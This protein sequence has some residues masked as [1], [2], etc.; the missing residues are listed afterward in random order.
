M[1]NQ[2][3]NQKLQTFLA[4]DQA[5]QAANGAPCD[6]SYYHR[7]NALD[8]RFAAHRVTDP[9]TTAS[10]HR[11]ASLIANPAQAICAR[12]DCKC[13]LIHVSYEALAMPHVVATGAAYQ[14][15]SSILPHVSYNDGDI[16]IPFLNSH[17]LG[18]LHAHGRVTILRDQDGEY[19]VWQ[20]GDPTKG[21]AWNVEEDVDLDLAKRLLGI[22]A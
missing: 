2:Y 17:P 18:G 14:L 19:A 12:D 20:D 21:A 22:D 3:L 5:K 13:K 1:R 11:L 15:D 7:F 6:A 4:T 16:K 9:L 8:L 10:Q